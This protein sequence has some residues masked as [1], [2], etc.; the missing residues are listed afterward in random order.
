MPDI[1]EHVKKAYN[2]IAVKYDNKTTEYNVPQSQKDITDC[3]L[4]TLSN[5]DTIV[6]IGCGGQP[7]VI[8]NVN[9]IGIDFS[10]NQL[11]RY[12]GDNVTMI[13]GDM[14]EIPVKNNTFDGLTAY[15]SLIHIPLKYHQK[16]INEFSRIVKTD[17]YIL[18]TEGSEEWVGEAD[19]WLDSGE[20]MSWEMAGKTKTREQLK[21]AGFE[22]K[23]IKPVK[24]NLGE[25]EGTK[26]FFL[27][28]K[29]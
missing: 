22:I 11:Q 13:Q 29:V 25:K 20:K 3:F 18:I 4:S 9:T 17:A 16:V 23:Q 26:Q 24:D 5:D 19:E 27:A 12:S 6:D 1:R 21:N 7:I 2:S 10:R 15:Y 14:V 8:D 28:Q